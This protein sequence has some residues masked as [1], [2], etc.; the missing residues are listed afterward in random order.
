LE[1]T[2]TWQFSNVL[3]ETMFY[4]VIPRTHPSTYLSFLDITSL[5]IKSYINLGVY[6][7]F[8]LVICTMET[9]IDFSHL[10]YSRSLIN[11]T[12][13]SHNDMYRIYMHLYFARSRQS[14]QANEKINTYIH[15]KINR[16]NTT[17]VTLRMHMAT[18]MI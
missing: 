10:S 15:S 5:H 17:I 16:H 12:L 2:D 3:F 1:Q 8:Y 4:L 11:C 6:F 18:D 14:T 13:T 9:N 7:Y